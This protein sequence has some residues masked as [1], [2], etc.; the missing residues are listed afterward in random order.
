MVERDQRG[1]CAVVLVILGSVYVLALT[2]LIPLGYMAMCRALVTKFWPMRGAAFA[3]VMLGTAVALDCVERDGVLRFISARMDGCRYRWPVKC[4]LV[5][6]R[7]G[8]IVGTKPVRPRPNYQAGCVYG[9]CRRMELRADRR[10]RFLAD[11]CDPVRWLTS[12]LN[13]AAYPGGG[14]IRQPNAG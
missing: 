11:D 7:L 1:R 3:A 4:L 9:L 13:M 12:E 8:G 6:G 10:E 5:S 14:G 2:V